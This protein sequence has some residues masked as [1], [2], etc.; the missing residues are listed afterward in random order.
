MQNNIFKK[1][2]ALSPFVYARIKGE[3]EFAQ[4]MGYVYFYKLPAGVIVMADIEGLPRT[5]NNIFAFHIHEGGN[6]EDN[7]ANTGGHFNPTEQTHPNHAGDLPPLFSNN[8][9]AWFAVY[10]ERFNPNE[11]IGKVVVVHLQVDDFTTQPAGNSG[12]K[13]ACGTIV[14]VN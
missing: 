3:N 4:V 14:K 12:E 13:I 6:C 10:T 9:Q 11:I 7:Y 8:G 1:L 2:C 5:D